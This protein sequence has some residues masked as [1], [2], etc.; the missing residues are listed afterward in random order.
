[1]VRQLEVLSVSD[2]G[3]HVLLATSEDATRATH[4]VRITNRL[5]AAINGELDDE[6]E[7]RESELSPKEIQARLRAGDSVEQVARAARIPVARI[8]IYATPVISERERII[9][10]ARAAKLRRPRGPESTTTLG[11]AVT[12]RLTEVAG[13]QPETVEW[14]AK[15]R[16]DASWLI[17]LS[18]AARGGTRSAQWVWRPHGRDLTAYNPL[19]SRMGTLDTAA[20]AK[21]R[22]A[23]TAAKA[24]QPRRSAAPAASRAPAGKTTSRSATTRKAVAGKGTTRK[25]AVKP[26]VR[27]PRP[28]PREAPRREQVKTADGRIVVPSWDDVLLG[29]TAPAASRGRR[30]S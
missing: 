9:D 20:P 15:R 2:D 3:N 23:S 18:F 8:M 27:K 17:T 1:M 7:H 11:N 14:T 26:A 28:E 6:D 4:Q 30:R 29:V 21:K 19:G 22:P 5:V 25:A 24:P 12:Q 16:E 10:Q 13:L